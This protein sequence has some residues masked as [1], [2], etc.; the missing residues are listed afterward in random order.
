MSARLAGA[1]A[2]MV[3]VVA[4]TLW[5]LRSGPVSRA[6]SGRQSNV[7]SQPTASPTRTSAP[8]GTGN[9]KKLEFS[10]SFSGTR[11]DTKVWATC[12]PWHDLPSGCTDYGNNEYQWYLP[13]QVRV[14]GGAL[15]LVARRIA[16]Q[17]LDS[18][19]APMK[20]ACRSGMVT[21]YPS[22]RFKYGYVQ[23]VA[24]LTN[25]HGLWP[26]LWLA[27]ANQKWPPEIDIVEHWGSHDQTGLF[28]HPIGSGQFGQRVKTADLTVGWHTF[29]LSWTRSRVVWFIDGHELMTY[30]LHVPH[31]TMYFIANLAE[32]G[33]VGR[34]D[35]AGTMVVRSVKVWSQ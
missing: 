20:Y 25:S 26:A 28:I 16:T 33:R 32:S 5:G 6:A 18:H 23:V 11:L 34:Q 15:H 10:A 29:G 22:F 9:T 1:L 13:S 27:A 12:F 2:A 30:D 21:T 8:A 19:G 35:C 31:Q 3:V 14:S 7:S 4:L 17:G 24:R